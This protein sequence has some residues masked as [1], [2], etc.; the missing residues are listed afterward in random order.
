MAVCLLPLP[1]L[2]S[3]AVASWA[4]LLCAFALMTIASTYPSLP[5]QQVPRQA[6]GTDKLLSGFAAALGI[7]H[8][9]LGG[10][11][12][13][14]GCGL[15]SR[16]ST[17]AVS[18]PAGLLPGAMW[19]CLWMFLAAHLEQVCVLHE[20]ARHRGA[21]RPARPPPAHCGAA[22]VRPAEPCPQAPG[23]PGPLLGADPFGGQ[24]WPG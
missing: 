8:R 24:Q 1:T 10:L 20:A 16:P 15:G 7:A 18:R 12:A 14:A 11:V 21:A 22:G 6:L 3:V 2:E 17:P 9:R 19:Q 4:G 5:V 13:Q 23:A